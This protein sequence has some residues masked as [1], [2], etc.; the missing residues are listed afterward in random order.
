VRGTPGNPY[1]I[2]DYGTV[3]DIERGTYVVQPQDLP[4]Y[5][6]YQCTETGVDLCIRPLAAGEQNNRLGA[7]RP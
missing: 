2:P 7:Y 1:V 3:A 6:V 5:Q 4:V